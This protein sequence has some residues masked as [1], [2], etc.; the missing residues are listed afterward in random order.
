VPG[1]PLVRSG[2]FTSFWAAPGVSVESDE[3]TFHSVRRLGVVETGR[4]DKVVHLPIQVRTAQPRRRA[5]ASKAG[6]VSIPI[7]SRPACRGTFNLDP[8]TAPLAARRYFWWTTT[9][10]LRADPLIHLRFRSLL[11][12]RDPR[13]RGR[14]FFQQRE[15]FAAHRRFEI[16]EAG[17]VASWVVKAFDKSAANGIGDNNEDIR[18]RACLVPQRNGRGSCTRHDHIRMLIDQLGGL[19]AHDTGVARRP[20]QVETKI[21]A[22][23]PAGSLEPLSQHPPASA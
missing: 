4:V 11:L 1:S 6:E 21:S 18:H 14:N 2:S 17:R 7:R 9:H 19:R 10:C 5:I 8:C 23:D 3:R 13:H 15:P 22:F 16:R 20:P 12:P